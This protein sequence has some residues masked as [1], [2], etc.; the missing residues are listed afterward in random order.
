MNKHQMEI[1][2]DVCYV[3]GFASVLGSIAIWSMSKSPDRSHGER[4]G[5]FVGLWA[6]TFF[7]L[8]N[9]L[10]TMAAREEQKQIEGA[11]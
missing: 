1:L 11:V 8:S 5:I 3:A 9:R 2:S 7:A 6:P 4:F 10:D